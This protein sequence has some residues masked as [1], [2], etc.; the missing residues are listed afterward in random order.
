VGA[1]PARQPTGGNIANHILLGAIAGMVGTAAMTVAMRALHRRLETAERYPLPPREIIDR[2]LPEPSPEQLRRTATIASHFGYGAAMG[3]LFAL[4]PG[5]KGPL[6]GAAYGVLVWAG[7]YLGWIPWAKILRNAVRHPLRRNAL[8][9]TV[10]LVWGAGTALTLRELERAQAEIFFQGEPRDAPSVACADEARPR[11][12][13][14]RS[15][16]TV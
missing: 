12:Q 1:A 9:N 8:M 15:R 14:P 7:S 13:G 3:A 6:V 11:S 10:H 4:A 2:V 5:G 16:S